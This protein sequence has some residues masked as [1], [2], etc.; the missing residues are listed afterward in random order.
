MVNSMEHNVS[1]YVLLVPFLKCVIYM[2]K[3]GNFA[4]HR[5]YDL[6]S[7]EEKPILDIIGK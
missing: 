1:K 2:V 4:D 7:S 5:L 6:K 3:S